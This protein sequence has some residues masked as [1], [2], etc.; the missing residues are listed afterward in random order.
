MAENTEAATILTAFR[1]ILESD[2]LDAD[3]PYRERS[4]AQ[5][6]AAIQALVRSGAADPSQIDA[7]NSVKE[8]RSD[9]VHALVG[10][11]QAAYLQSAGRIEI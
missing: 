3:S 6:D 1:D 4:V 2:L 9:F 10:S 8:Y 7:Y 5:V 11:Q